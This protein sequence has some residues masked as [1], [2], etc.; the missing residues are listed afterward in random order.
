VS[1]LGIEDT[2]RTDGGLLNMLRR[3]LRTASAKPPFFGRH[4][5]RHNDTVLRNYYRRI[6]AEIVEMMRLRENAI[7]V[8][9]GAS[10]AV[11]PPNP[12]SS[13]AWDCQFFALCP[14]LDDDREDHELFIEM[15][16]TPA[17]PLARYE[18]VGGPD[19]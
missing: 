6:Y 7:S 3:T 11:A 5:V 1:L 4:E 15:A 12:M 8:D 14:M 17:D 13:C 9:L 18:S 19:E 16:Y 10:Q 2:E